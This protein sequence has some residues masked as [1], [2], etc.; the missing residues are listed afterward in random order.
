MSGGRR[1]VVM[2]PQTRLARSRPAAGR[3]WRKPPLEVHE[4]ERA[5]RLYRAQRRHAVGTVGLLVVLVF[6]LPPLL[7]LFAAAGQLRLFGVPLS[8]AAL[9]LVPFPSM[10]LL[11]WRQSRRAESLERRR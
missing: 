5:G 2:S 1:T 8:W 10:V 3:R 6:G 9:V 11:A 4:S 7:G